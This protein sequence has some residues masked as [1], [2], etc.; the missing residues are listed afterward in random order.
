MSDTSET[1]TV[2]ISYFAEDG[3]YGS[4]NGVLILD[5]TAWSELDWQ[6]VEETQDELRPRVARLIAESYEPG[7][8]Q[9]F[10]RKKLE[11]EHGFDFSSHE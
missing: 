11:E 7:A 3:N 9:K 4:G 5:T 2:S 1:Q 6:M 10:L 8:D